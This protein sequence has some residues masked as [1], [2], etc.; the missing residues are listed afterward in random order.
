[1]EYLCAY[2]WRARAR[3]YVDVYHWLCADPGLYKALR[4]VPMFCFEMRNEAYLNYEMIEFQNM[5]WEDDG[6]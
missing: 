5:V 2:G 3:H 6:I 4:D 1:M